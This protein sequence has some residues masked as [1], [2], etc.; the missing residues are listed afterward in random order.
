[1]YKSK[2]LNLNCLL[3]TEGRTDFC[4]KMSLDNKIVSKK[5]YIHIS[6]TF[7]CSSKVTSP[8][9]WKGLSNTLMAISKPLS[10]LNIH[11]RS[12]YKRV[13]R[14]ERPGEWS[15]THQKTQPRYPNAL[16]PTD[17]KSIAKP[18]PSLR[19]L[20]GHTTPT[21]RK[22]AAIHCAGPP[23]ERRPLLDDESL[24]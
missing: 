15:G 13:E 3:S 24:N 23:K 18:H 17:Q 22:S 4:L 10:S 19:F 12:V 16:L 2:L 11:F 9:T 14:R 8:D 6:K 7:P 1:M 20:S 21:Y 5:K